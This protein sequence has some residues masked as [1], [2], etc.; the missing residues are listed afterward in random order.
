VHIA[1]FYPIVTALE[2][3]AIFCQAREIKKVPFP[4][5][6]SVHTLAMQA[7]IFML[8]AVAWIWNLPFDYKEFRGQWGWG[9]FAMWYSY[10]GWVIVNAFIFGLGQTALMIM[11]L[12]YSSMA[13]VIQCGETAPLLG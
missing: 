11:A 3:L 6:L 10:V 4:N 12:R 7:F 9:T 8:I 1:I 2:M 5:V 13:N